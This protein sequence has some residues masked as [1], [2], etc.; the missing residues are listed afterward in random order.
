MWTVTSALFGRLPEISTTE[1]NSLERAPEGQGHAGQHR[2]AD[3]VVDDP[4][5][6]HERLE[7]S[8]AAASSTSGSSLHQHVRRAP[9]DER[10]RHEQQGQPDADS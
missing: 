10:Q 8:E 9:H 4:A 7:P 3:G 6:D 1:P 2:R 5:N